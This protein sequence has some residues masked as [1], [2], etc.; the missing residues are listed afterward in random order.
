MSRKAG[1]DYY[2]DAGFQ[3]VDLTAKAVV[4]PI[5]STAGL[6]VRVCESL[7]DDNYAVVDDLMGDEE[8]LALRREIEKMYRDGLMAD[9]EIGNGAAASQGAVKHTLRTDKV[10]WLEGSEACVGPMLKRHI[11]RLDILSQKVS[12][13][14]EAVAPEHTWKGASRSKIMATCYAGTGARYVPHY[15]N[16]NANGRKLTAIVYLNTGWTKAHGGV[17]RLKSNKKTVDIAPLLDR[18]LLFWSDT[19]CPHEV[20]PATGPDRFAITIWY[21]DEVERDAAEAATKKTSA[22]AEAAATT[23]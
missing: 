8:A 7:M 22:F 5:T 11:T 10:I 16:P 1:N 18:L 21:M 20:L 14:F 9:G 23:T 6:T 15:D 4:D 19:R 3:K 12:A 13:F 17:L 2:D